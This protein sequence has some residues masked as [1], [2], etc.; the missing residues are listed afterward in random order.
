MFKEIVNFFDEFTL[1]RLVLIAILLILFIIVYPVIDTNFLY[2]NRIDNRI[3]VLTS[4]QNLDTEFVH[5][6]KVIEEEFTNILSMISNQD[7]SLFLDNGNIISRS[8]SDTMKVLKF[9]SGSIWIW[10]MILFSPFIFKEFKKTLQGILVLIICVL[11][12]GGLGLLI[13]SFNLQLINYIG[14]PLL[15]L[16]ILIGFVYKYSEK[17]AN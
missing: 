7:E 1:K 5:S 14:F 2:F 8:T 6:N 17:K 11:L 15:Q 4:L 12:L 13:P 16:I 10:L 3:D 9:I